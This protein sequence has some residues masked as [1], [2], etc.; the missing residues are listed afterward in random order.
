MF[1]IYTIVM[2]S[3]CVTRVHLSSIVSFTRVV[4]SLDHWIDRHYSEH[5]GFVQCM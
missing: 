4:I 2:F 3:S 5:I 1:S